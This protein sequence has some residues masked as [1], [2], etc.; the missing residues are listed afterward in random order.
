MEHWWNDTDM[1][2][3]KYTGVNSVPVPIFPPQIPRD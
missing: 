2:N 1:R 3:P